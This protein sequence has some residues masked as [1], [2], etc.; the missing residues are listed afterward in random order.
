M[1]DQVASLP[2]GRLAEMGDAGKS[3]AIQNFNRERC[4][5]QIVQIIETVAA[6]RS[7][8]RRRSQ[9]NMIGRRR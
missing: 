6:E 3:Y 5:P 7:S 4:L 1:I 8:L 9:Q 2:K